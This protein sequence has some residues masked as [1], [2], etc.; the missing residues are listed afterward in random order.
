VT[1]GSAGAVTLELARGSIDCD[2]EHRPDR[3]PFRVIAGEVTVHVVGTRF[4]VVREGAHVR[5]DVTAGQVRITAP[6]LERLVGGG[7]TWSSVPPPPLPTPRP[8]PRTDAPP[9]PPP[10]PAPPAKAATS[11][12][13]YEAAQRL[14]TR[15]RHAA[16]RAYRSAA[17]GHGTWAALA[18]W[19]LAE[20]EAGR[21]SAGSRAALAAVAEYL[22]R[23]PR[24]ANAEDAA[25]LRVEVSRTTRDRDGAREAA[26]DYL[27]RFPAGTYV[28]P[29]Q[30]IVDAA[31]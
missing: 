16:A 10:T 27:G 21:G 15:D 6:G 29:A 26:V 8:A 19:G 4:A 2:V 30:R 18:L 17:S 25:W 7:D 5:V 23:F 1:R 3:P 11:R 12:A 31:P 14:E 13:A 28:K 24:G 9:P 20:L 22:R